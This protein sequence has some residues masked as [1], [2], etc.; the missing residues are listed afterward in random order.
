MAKRVF[1]PGGGD[2][3]WEEDYYYSGAKFEDPEGVWEEQVTVSYRY[4]SS[5][6]RISYLGT[7]QQIRAALAPYEDLTD[8]VKEG[9]SAASSV[10][11]NW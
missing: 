10:V 11:T 4:D 1:K 2:P 6:L 7:N 5:R 8:R 3:I 9:L